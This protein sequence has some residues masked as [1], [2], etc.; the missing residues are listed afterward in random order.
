MSN[1]LPD[2]NIAFKQ[3]AQTFIQRGDNAILI[4]KDDTDKTF[5]SVEYKDLI[6][7]EIDKSKY[8]EENLQ[9]IKDCLESNPNKVI[10]VRIDTEE[11][12]SDALS[13]VK[14]LYNTGWISLV[15]N[16]QA[17]YDAL[18]QWIKTRRDVDKKT[19]KGIVFNPTTQPDCEGIVV[20][21][22]SKVTFKDNK[23]GEKEGYEYLPSLLGYI[24]S[25]GIDTG[26]TYMT[27]KNLKSVLE[28]VNIDQEIQSGKLILINDENTVK[29]GLGVNSLTTF[30]EGKGE[31]FSLIEVIEATDLIKDDI[32]NTFKNNYV[33]KFKNKLDNQILFISAIN[34]YFKNLAA[35]DVLDNAFNNKCYID[36]EAQRKAWI[37]SGKTEAKEWAEEEVKGNIFKRD[38]FL[39]ANIK[40]LSTMTDLDFSITME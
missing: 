25:A 40:I 3:R 30:T 21:G 36:I 10:V 20:L 4:L 39:A 35:R 5:E 16:A 1:T 2:I 15:S 28:P 34:T 13:T 17:D 23:R 6:E 32:K 14:N 31:D 12:Y 38:I 24:A 37:E 8:T 18:I 29:I 7:L 9:Y 27:M 11:Q 26:T 19:F 22:N 33:G